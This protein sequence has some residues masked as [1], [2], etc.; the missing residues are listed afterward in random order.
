LGLHLLHDVHAL[1][2]FSKDHV[3]A[4]EPRSGGRGDEELRTVGCTNCRECGENAKQKE[5]KEKKGGGKKKTQK[6]VLPGPEL[7]MERMPGPV[8]FKLKFSS[9]NLAP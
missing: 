6:N 8:C 9:A 5:E 7:A 4:I 2:H 3:L 1:N